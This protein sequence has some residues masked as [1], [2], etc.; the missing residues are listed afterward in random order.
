MKGTDFTLPFITDW[1][2]RGGRTVSMS[3]CLQHLANHVFQWLSNVHVYV[4]R[5]YKNQGQTFLKVCIFF[6]LFFENRIKTIQQ[7]PFF[8]YSGKKTQTGAKE[9]AEISPSTRKITI[10]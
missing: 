7:I 9:E 10:L 3:I 1:I 4:W 8:T 2:V 6:G 5:E